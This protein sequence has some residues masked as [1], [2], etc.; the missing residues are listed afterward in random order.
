MECEL[1]QNARDIFDVSR[2]VE[3]GGGGG[4]GGTW[5]R[6]P[7]LEG[8]EVGGEEEEGK[9]KDADDGVSP[10]SARGEFE[11]GDERGSELDFGAGS[12]LHTR[13][14][15]SDIESTS[16][17][18]TVRGTKK[19][20]W[21]EGDDEAAVVTPA[22]SQYTHTFLPVYAAPVANTPVSTANGSIK[23]FKTV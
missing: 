21:S 13:D 8:R 16:D 3:E 1:N 10:W 2:V 18:A 22:P 7:F 4:E 15:G 5:F 14:G 19:R 6:N 20:A 11:E 9:G 23:R 17:S 12:E